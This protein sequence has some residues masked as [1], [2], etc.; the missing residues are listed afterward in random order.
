MKTETKIEII[1]AIDLSPYKSNSLIVA[2]INAPENMS[3]D[4]IDSVKRAFDDLKNKFNID[5]STYLFIVVGEDID[6]K[7]FDEA[8]MNEMGWFKK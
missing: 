3:A 6:I 5:D 1:K 7:A 2:K 8:D 4:F